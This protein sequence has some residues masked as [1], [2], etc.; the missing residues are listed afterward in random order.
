MKT[1]FP[2]YKFMTKRYPRPKLD[3]IFS[4]VTPY[5]WMAQYQQAP[6]LGDMAFFRTENLPHYD[7]PNV[8]R[9]WI[10]VDAAQTATRG[11]SYSAGV[12]LGWCPEMNKLLVLDVMRGKWPQDQLEQEVVAQFHGVTRLC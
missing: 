9:C 11:G 4:T 10:A 3:E 8:V 2:P 6:T 12:A 5:F 1:Y 7:R